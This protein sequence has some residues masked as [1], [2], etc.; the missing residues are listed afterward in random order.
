MLPGS[1]RHS[2]VLVNARLCAVR[3]SQRVAEA[4]ALGPGP[5]GLESMA[6]NHRW[7]PQGG[8]STLPGEELVQQARWK[9]TNTLGVLHPGWVPG[10]PGRGS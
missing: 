3:D 8:T 6:G 2:K 7:R 1:Q 10:S 5:L 9:G 4:K